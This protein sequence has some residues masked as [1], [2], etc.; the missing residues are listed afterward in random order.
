[1]TVFKRKIV[2]LP[3]LLI[4]VV[5]AGYFL[6]RGSPPN[7]EFATARRGTVVQEVS[8]TGKIKSADAVQLAFERSGRVSR[9]AVDSGDR[10]SA[11][12]VVAE[13]DSR[14][15][16]AELKRARAT[17]EVQRSRLAELQR[18][19][20]PEELAIAEAKRANAAQSLRDAERSLSDKIRD[21]YAKADDAVRYRTD[22]VFTDPRSSNP[23][24]NF[25]LIDPA[26]A[27][28]LEQDR[29][30]IERALGDWQASLA[31]LGS[32]VEALPF[33]SSAQENLRIVA[34][35]LDTVAA[36]VNS[37]GAT[38]TLS[39]AAIDTHRSSVS[40]ARVNVNAAAISL[41]AA[42]EARNAAQANAT[43]AG[44]EL[45]LKQAGATPEAITS[46][47]AQLREAEANAAAL[48]AQAEKY[49]LRSPIAGVVTKRTAEV[50]EV[51][52]ANAPVISV[53]STN[54]FEIEANVSEV[55]IAKLQV[56]Q[57][58]RV[59]LDAY[60]SDVPFGARIRVIYPGETVI[61]G[62][63]TYRVTL[64]FDESVSRVRAGMTAAID[65]TTATREG[66]IVLP[67]RA[68]GTQDGKRVVR[69]WGENV[70][71]IVRVQTGLRGLDGNVEVLRGVREGDRVL[72][73][74]L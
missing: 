49:E 30:S 54:R 35:F 27:P 53:I 9:L 47:E 71:R 6:F 25:T 48:E 20:R 32:G 29:R 70:I 60:G 26:L 67:Q 57:T 37:L 11:G 22:P 62:V 4:A 34:A 63:P 51:V 58:A 59:T 19:T 50:G 13:L 40:A 31:S 14:E 17:V 28:K 21:A 46:G 38:D 56:G 55:D 42:A 23:R 2:W 1:M 41:S 74:E 68:I 10:V 7:P 5:A 61:D 3:A 64:H 69:I 43:I 39:Q 45:A 72:I 24:F 15:A 73:P 16:A 66:V 65:V 33:L 36:A 44:E 8:V 18:G 52:A 12:A